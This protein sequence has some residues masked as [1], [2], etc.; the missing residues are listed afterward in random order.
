MSSTVA[1]YSRHDFLCSFF[2]S[3][4]FRS[5]IGSKNDFGGKDTNN[6]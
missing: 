1:M 5:F 6:F 3:D 4:F 2:S